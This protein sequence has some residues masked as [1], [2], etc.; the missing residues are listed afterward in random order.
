M[1][2]SVLQCFLVYCNI[3]RCTGVPL[4]IT[5]A[6]MHKR[7][8]FLDRSKDGHLIFLGAFNAQLYLFNDVNQFMLHK[9]EGWSHSFGILDV[10][11][12]CAVFHVFLF[13]MLSYARDS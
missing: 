1:H 12:V 11:A 3:E 8:H 2:G 13:L 9:K 5:G 6:A 4:T 7:N 10:Y